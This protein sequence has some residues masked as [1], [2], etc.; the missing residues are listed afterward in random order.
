MDSRTVRAAGEIRAA[1]PRR[2]GS[3]RR[4]GVGPTGRRGDIAFRAPAWA[5]MPARCRPRIPLPAIAIE[6]SGA[7]APGGHLSRAVS[8]AVDTGDHTGNT[9]ELR[10]DDSS[11]CHCQTAARPSPWRRQSHRSR[12]NRA[13]LEPQRIFVEDCG[14]SGRERIVEGSDGGARDL[15]EWGV[16]GRLA[17]S[18]ALETR[19]GLQQ[20]LDF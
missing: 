15:A 8:R 1:V 19:L 12:L 5:A 10:P 3:A 7:V 4:G 20:R 17:G 16:V 2:C 6:L 18:R 11:P 14:T 9:W 13:R